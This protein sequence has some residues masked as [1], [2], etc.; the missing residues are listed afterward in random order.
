MQVN[1]RNRHSCKVCTHTKYSPSGACT[2]ALAAAAAQRQQL[3]A[4]A[5]SAAG[6]SGVIVAGTS[7]AAAAAAAAAGV[8]T[9]LD[10]STIKRM[11][12]DSSVPSPPHNDSRC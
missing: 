9:G 2:A 10:P 8:L 4:A 5:Q 3:H 11:E 1:I 7:A 6:P 12:C